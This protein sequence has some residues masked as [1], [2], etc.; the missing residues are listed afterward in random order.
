MDTVQPNKIKETIRTPEEQLRVITDALSARVARCSRDFRYLW[1]SRPFAE[2]IGRSPEEVVGRPIAE[3]IGPEAFERLSPYFKR[4]LSGEKVRYEEE[5][6]LQGL[7]PQWISAVYTPTFDPA[8]VADGWVT[9]VADIDDRKRSEEALQRFQFSMEHAPDAVFF[10][11]RDAGFSYVNEQAC[12]S[13]GYTRDELLRLKLW[14][15]DPIYPR[16]RWEKVWTEPDRNPE[17]PTLETLHR[18]KDGTVFPVEVS[19]EHLWLGEHEFHVAFVRDITR[20]KEA[21]EALKAA[22]ARLQLALQAGRIGT[23]DWNMS[24]GQI[25]WSRGHE[26]LWGMAP[27][28]FKG[29]YEEF[30]ARLH[31]ADRDGLSRALAQAVAGRRTF[32]HEFRVVWPDGSVHWVAGQGEPFFD[33]DGKPVRMIGVVRDITE[34]RRA[35]EEVSL[36][37]TIIL[38]IGESPNLS[39]ALQVVLEKICEVT[40]WGI[41]Q[42]WIPQSDGRTLLCSPAWYGGRDGRFKKLRAISR[43]M[44]IVP[45]EG[46]P[47]RALASKQPV[48]AQ[49]VSREKNCRRA[50]YAGEVGVRSGLAVPVM[51][52]DRVLA[53]LEW[54]MPESR[55]EDERL[56]R[57]V[58]TLA[59]QLGVVIERKR[60]EEALAAEKE[61]LAVTIRSIGDGVIATDVEGKVILM[62]PVAESFT[63]RR[64]EEALGRPLERIFSIVDEK[65][66]AELENPAIRAVQTGKTVDPINDT[67]LISRDGTERIIA[68]RAA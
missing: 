61:R 5:I 31:P 46:L 24:T 35:E 3:V 54:Y 48:W 16:E 12:R 25:V 44:V 58:S 32:R 34:Q 62:N 7:G 66:R 23:W 30:D 18:R 33:E 49:D 14:A 28:A 39:A 65:S 64:Q 13:L 15:I 19:A 55:E 60:S 27:G 22:E 37:Q 53:V 36:L 8:G 63:G 57:L 11:T 10:M 21:A 68:N 26:E 29:T 4:V 6:T 17:K 9:A 45:D 2:W 59:S 1:V 42:A 20:R 52:G 41:G 51:A 67:I 40:G 50:P 56:I 38:A 43:E 47:G